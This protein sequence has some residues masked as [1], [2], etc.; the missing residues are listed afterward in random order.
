MEFG[1][2]GGVWLKTPGAFQHSFL[3]PYFPRGYGTGTPFL[4]ER[5]EARQDFFS[6]FRFF[7]ATAGRLE[8]LRA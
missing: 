4:A 3:I 7:F 2:N 5:E 1:L 6:I 8:Y